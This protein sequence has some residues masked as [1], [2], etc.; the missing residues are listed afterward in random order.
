MDRKLGFLGIVF[1]FI[2]ALVGFYI[3]LKKQQTPAS[4]TFKAIPINA[5]LI[6]EVQN[7]TK[8]IKQISQKNNLW[9]ELLNLKELGLFQDKLVGL[10]SLLSNQLISEDLLKQKELIVSFHE[11]GNNKYKPIFYTMFSGR[12]EGNQVLKTIEQL[13][14]NKGK[15][16][17]SRYNQVKVFSFQS[18]SNNKLSFFYGFHKGILIIS[19]SEILI[20]DAIRQTE[21]DQGLLQEKQFTKLRETAGDYVDANIYVQFDEFQNMLGSIIDLNLLKS[22]GIKKYAEWGVLDLNIKNNTYLFNGF[23]GSYNEKSRITKVF[24]GQKPQNLKF[25]KHISNMPEAFTLF[26]ISNAKTFRQNLADY[27]EDIGQKDRFDVNE[28]SIRNAFGNQAVNDIEELVKNELALVTLPNGSTIFAMQTSGYRNSAELIQRFF[29]N[30][31][32]STNTSISAYQKTYKIDNDTEFLIYEMPLK[33]FP[34][35]MFGPWFNNCKAN[36]VGLFDDYIIFADTYKSLTNFIYNNVLQKTIAYNGAYKEFENYLSSKTNYYQFVSLT[37]TGKYI[38]RWLTPASYKYVLTNQEQLKNFYGV[39]LQFSV[40]NNLI[41]NSLLFRNQPGNTIQASTEWE[42]KL[43]TSLR[44]KPV[45]LRNHYTGNK[46][47]FIQDQQNAIYLLNKSGR[48][49]WKQKLNEPILG[50]VHQVD[51][52][53]NGKLQIL[54]NTKSKIHI[55]DRNGNYVDRY[56]VNLPE[57]ASAPLAL[58]DYDKRKNYRIFIPSIDNNVYCYNI[59]GKKVS[60]FKFS[61]TDY[62]ISKPVQYFRNS[63]K[64]YL[65]VCDEKRTYILNRKGNERLKLD[66]QFEISKNNQYTIQPS[67]GNNK[68]RIVITDKNGVIHFVY[69]DGTIQ[70]KTLDTFTENHFFNIEDINHDGA[71]EYIYIDEKKLI[72]YSNQG[73]EIFTYKF[74]SKILH[75]PS[76]YKFSSNNIGIGVTETQQNKI[77]IINEKGKLLEGFPLKGR[78][79]FSVGL[80][81]QGTGRFNLFVG[82]DDFYLYNYKLN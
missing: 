49:L 58:F 76:F 51:F 19:P 54:F 6:L 63:N 7:P 38:E 14:Q 11:L 60:G 52:Y 35:R 55:I 81:S 5:A 13:L 61:G 57:Q 34:T 30:Y 33:K 68:A 18:N 41:Y 10:D 71:D 53:K 28:Q 1:V 9:N 29:K 73:K 8:F 31:S 56:P 66:Q 12:F 3:Y 21:S 67:S 79:R 50:Q 20:Q 78:T 17:S 80:M 77:H 4:S 74:S 43:D 23:S 42:S 22:T 36:Y 44:F 46:E 32:K 72:A 26:G 69:F 70:T 62:S 48:I 37:G 25:I 39:A 47:V 65:V 2:F 40:D 75:A 59:Q 24:T 64:D 15:L 45:L 82:G 27:M 16:I